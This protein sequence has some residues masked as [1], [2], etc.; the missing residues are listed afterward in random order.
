M[1]Q[2]QLVFGGAVLPNVEVGSV[3]SPNAWDVW[4]NGAYVS[5]TPVYGDQ[6][7]ADGGTL[8]IGGGN[9]YADP[10][11]VGADGGT[12]VTLDISPGGYPTIVPIEVM[13]LTSTM[14][15][16]VSGTATVDLSSTPNS[17]YLAYNEADSVINLAAHATMIGTDSLQ[18]GSLTVNGG[19]STT[20]DTVG[21]SSFLGTAVTLNTS[22]EGTGILEIGQAQRILYPN[23]VSTGTY[24]GSLTIGMDKVGAGVSIQLS[25]AS[26]TLDDPA[27]FQGQIDLGHDSSVFLA[28]VHA[29]SWNIKGDILKL[30]SGSRVVDSLN[31]TDAPAQAYGGP[32][33]VQA[34]KGSLFISNYE[35]S[36]VGLPLHS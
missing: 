29:D 36:G 24:D 10:I 7:V 32:V 2:R 16:N 22:V 11:L 21:F 20:W 17:G 3:Y 14:T 19:A 34:I 18:F 13:A 1:T 15:A 26:L 5:A 8:L 23:I 12:P 9:V 27:A 4:S 28:G 33:T 35:P 31:L 25:N 30:Y 6:L